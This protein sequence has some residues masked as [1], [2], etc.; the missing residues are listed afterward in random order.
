MLQ[1]LPELPPVGAE[2]RMNPQQ[3]F[4]PGHWTFDACETWQSEG[5]VW[6]EKGGGILRTRSA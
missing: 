3:V 6:E 1:S 2:A 4:P 5:E